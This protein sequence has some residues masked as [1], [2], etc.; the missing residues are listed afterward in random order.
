M[1]NSKKHTLNSNYSRIL[2]GGYLRKLRYPTILIVVVG[3]CF[4]MLQQS[5]RETILQEAIIENTLAI[6]LEDEPTNYIPAKDSGYTL[7]IEKSSCTNGV[8]VTFD[9]N[10]W[11]VKTNYSN[12]ESTNNTRVKCSLYFTSKYIEP[13]LNGTDPVLEDPLIPVTISDDGTVKKTDLSSEWYDYETKQWANA[14][15]LFD[16][17]KTYA[18][19]DVI[20]EEEIESYFVWIPKYRYQLWDLGLYDSLTTIDT[21]KVHEIPVI[22]GDYNTNDSVAGECTT[23]MKSGESGNCQVGD[24]ITHPAFLSISSTGFWVGKFETGYAGATSTTEAE[25]NEQDASKV[26]VKPNAYSWRNID[27]ANA[28]YTSYDYQRVLDSHMMKN[29]EWGAVAY[30]EHSAYG[31]ATKI[32]MNNNSDYITGYQ[33]NEEATCGYTETNEEC[34][35]YCNDNT[36]NTAYPNSTLA[37]STNNITG[38]YDLSGGSWEHVM[39]VMLDE[40]GNPMSG[41]NSIYNSG[42]N[43]TLGCPTCDND[44]SGLTEITNGYEWPEEKYYDTYIYNTSI[45]VY[46]QRILGD[47]SDESGPFGTIYYYDKRRSI[48]SWYMENAHSL[49]LNGAWVIRGGSSFYGKDGGIFAF[50]NNNPILIPYTSFRLI[51]TPTTPN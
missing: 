42:F 40:E 41:R 49:A 34:N 24:Y 28:F 2:G 50:G 46:L 18:S 19:G 12:Y 15:I 47:A 43:G 23:P 4:F 36:C 48:G 13:L 32:R 27:I 8:E 45:Y 21:S 25:V 33:A 37:S 29:T 7:D 26:I 35:R 1:K 16:E 17:S 39:A 30:L 44:T 38:I 31:S 22:F 3:A 51:L 20:P 10:T 5:K 11:S 6:Y 14:V 9:Y